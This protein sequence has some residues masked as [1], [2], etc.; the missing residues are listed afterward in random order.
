MSRPC[1][2]LEVSDLP[3]DKTR[4][5]TPMQKVICSTLNYVRSNPEKLAV[6]K[7]TMKFVHNHI[8]VYQKSLVTEEVQDG[9]P[10]VT[11]QVQVEETEEVEPEEIVPV[12]D[13]EDT[14]PESTE[15]S[16]NE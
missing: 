2:R 12:L 3:K 14:Q 16:T 9:T 10:V 15:E 7:E 4:A 13:D 6:L 1:P 5:I 8:N 11:V